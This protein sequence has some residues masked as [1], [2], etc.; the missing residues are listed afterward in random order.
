M[1]II[2][3]GFDVQQM[4]NYLN[5]N[6]RSLVL[7]KN[8]VN[9]DGGFRLTTYSDEYGEYE[10]YGSLSRIIIEAFKPFVEQ[11]KEDRE[12]AKSL[13]DSITQK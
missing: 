11:A 9:E 5:K 6:S 7:V 12:K 3:L 1:S 10:G 8:D 4:L 13:L 2:Y